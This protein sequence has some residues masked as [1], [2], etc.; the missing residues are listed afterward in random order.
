MTGRS[1]YLTTARDLGG[2]ALHAWR[3]FRG[4]RCLA[5]A[6]SLSYTTL[7]AIVPL[8]AVGLA[9]F[10]AFPVFE[11]VQETLQKFLF[12]NFVP[13]AGEIVRENLTKFVANTGQLTAIGIVILAVT[14][15][16]LLSTIEESFNVIWRQSVPRRLTIRLITY[17][18]ILTLTPL[19]IGGSLALSSY[20]FTITQVLRIEAFEGPLGGLVRI[21]PFVLSAVGF[22]FLYVIMPNRQVRWRHALAGGVTAAVLFQVLKFI[23]VLY[24]TNFPSFETIYGAV[25]A[26]PLFLIWMYVTWCTVLVGAELCASIPEWRLDGQRARAPA[27]DPAGRLASALSVLA[28]LSSEQAEESRRTDEALAEAAGVDPGHAT[29]LFERLIAARYLA[30]TADDH[31]VLCRDLGASS[32]YDFA[33][34]MGLML[35]A[36]APGKDDPPWRRR[37][38]Q[39]VAQAEKSNHR[40][41]KARLGSLFEQTSPSDKKPKPPEQKKRP[42]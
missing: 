41:M 31:L 29:A 25:S 38:G 32:L 8:A 34:A 35:N 28:A 10:S 19:L 27:L 37:L 33:H 1:K 15:L 30:R 4:D 40:L 2:L 24:V 13:A 14:A 36:G 12:S 6:A 22:A 26:I 3:R 42:G 9:T 7:L 21:L 39:I 20:I 18:A 5:V 23:F 17:W 11:G 16:M